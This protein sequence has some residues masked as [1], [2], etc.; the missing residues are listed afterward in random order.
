MSRGACSH[1]PFDGGSEHA[2][3]RAH[4]GSFIEPCRGAPPRLDSHPSNVHPAKMKK[5]APVHDHTPEAIAARISGA[6]NHSYVGDGMLGAI[7]GT[8]TTFAIVAASSG[9]GFSPGVALVLGFSNVVADGFSMAVSNYLRAKSDLDVLNKARLEE[10]HHIE[11]HPDGEREEIRQIY[12]A[13]GF[14]GSTL[15]A[16]V[17]GITAD[18]HRWI[19]TML[20]DELGL[21]LEVPDPVRAGVTTFL[22]FLVAGLVPLLALFAFRSF[23]ASAITTAVTFVVIGLAKAKF[24]G[25]RMITSAA[26]ALLVGGGAAAL[27]YFVAAWT[28]GL[29]A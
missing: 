23:P 2:I 9:A 17:E 13:K 6:T 7:D 8:I 4:D 1:T 16:I 15:E 10:A 11:V 29:A 28:R 5:H 27:A 26:E 19:D 22:A 14:E 18:R 25:G 21:R 12:A 3:E 20:T 24:V